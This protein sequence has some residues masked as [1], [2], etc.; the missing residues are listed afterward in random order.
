MKPPSKASKPHRISHVCDHCRLRKLKCSKDKPSCTRCTKLGLQC[1]YTP[2]RQST[3]DPTTVK[4]LEAELTYVKAQLAACTKALSDAQASIPVQM[5]KKRNI[6]WTNL[7]RPINVH[8]V[9]RTYY[10]PFSDL[11]LFARDPLSK[12]RVEDL[13]VQENEF[14]KLPNRNEDILLSMR[15]ILPE[16]QILRENKLA[17][18]TNYYQNYPFYN[19]TTFEEIHEGLIHDPSLTEASTTQICFLIM[20]FLMLCLTEKLAIDPDLIDGWIQRARIASDP[21]E[22][23]LACLLY[24]QLYSSPLRLC[25]TSKTRLSNDI[26]RMALELGLFTPASCLVN[27]KLRQNLWMGCVVLAEPAAFHEHFIKMFDKE[28]PTDNSPLAISYRFNTNLSNVWNSVVTASDALEE[29]MVS[30]SSCSKNQTH[31]TNQEG[32]LMASCR[33]SFATTDFNLLIMQFLQEE[34]HVRDTRFLRKRLQDLFDE[35]LEYFLNFLSIV[36]T[37]RYSYLSQTV[38]CLKSLA[39]YVLTMSSRYA[40]ENR[41]IEITELHQKFL[42]AAQAFPF[43]LDWCDQICRS[44]DDTLRDVNSSSSDFSDDVTVGILPDSLLEE[45]TGAFST[46]IDELSPSLSHES[47]ESILTDSLT[48]LNGQ[49]DARFAQLFP[50]YTSSSTDGEIDFD[51]DVLH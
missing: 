42:Q 9:W 38:F 39:S 27:N 18:E 44:L 48:G 20:T 11:A 10:A 37:H 12:I 13:F 30:L 4:A 3:R 33:L 1:V 8:G 6:C 26:C 16:P 36:A 25:P 32:A 46:G 21:S 7:V 5:P 34:F 29:D 40:R 23:N 15:R 35:L 28:V 50:D 47:F 43:K 17:F 24:L 49:L 41:H 51:F 45:Y 2:F 19:I 22:E 14:P 31:D